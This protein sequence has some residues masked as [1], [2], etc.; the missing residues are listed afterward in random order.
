MHPLN[1]KAKLHD[2]RAF[3]FDFDGVMTD[4]SVWTLENGE[5][6]RCGHAKDGYALQYAVRKGYEV[7]VITGAISKSI[8]NRLN[9]LGVQHVYTGCANKMETYRKWLEE[10]ALSEENVLFMGDDIPDYEL[11]QHCGV[12]TCPAD[13]AIEI[14]DM[15]DYISLYDGGKGCVR[16]V[17]EQVMRLQKTWFHADALIW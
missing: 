14:R 12:S 7:A 9:S 8:T 4:G 10:L 16:D 11:M 6:V 5:T 3:V 17:I 1:Y 13:A 2:I 15:A